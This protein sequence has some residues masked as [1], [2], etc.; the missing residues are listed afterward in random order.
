MEGQVKAAAA[1]RRILI[2]SWES[3]REAGVSDQQYTDLHHVLQ[4]Y[5]DQHLWDKELAQY[6]RFRQDMTTVDA[7]VLFKGRVVITAE[8]HHQVLEAIHRSH[9]GVTGMTLRT[10]DS[11]WWPGITV[12]IAAVR[13]C[14]RFCIQNAPSQPHLAPVHPQTPDFPFQL[15]SS[16]YFDYA[17]K[18]YLLI[19]DRYSNWTVVKLCKTSSA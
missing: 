10:G 17:G 19:V 7:I 11:V 14:C 9:R 5:K 6:K 3:V 12:D 2:T 15:I 16:D 1:S 8:L 18:S 13:E 4:S